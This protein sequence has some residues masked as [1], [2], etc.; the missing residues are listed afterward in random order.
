MTEIYFV[1]LDYHILLDEAVVEDERGDAR[2]L[3]HDITHSILFL[4]GNWR[5]KIRSLEL[6][7]TINGSDLILMVFQCRKLFVI[8]F[9][10]VSNGFVFHSRFFEW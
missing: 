6:L 9:K 2:F 1:L 8:L 10:N 3:W 4:F 7:E 5:G